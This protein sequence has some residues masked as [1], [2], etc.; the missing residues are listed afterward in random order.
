LADSALDSTVAVNAEAPSTREDRPCQGRVRP[1]R[2]QTAN[3]DPQP[4]V[5]DAGEVFAIID[6]GA[7]KILNAHRIHEQR[8]ARVLDLGV[9]VLH[10]FVEREAVLEAGASAPLDVDA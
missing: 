2:R 5:V 9:A 6:L 3:E 1:R 4:Q 8:D 10:L 7:L